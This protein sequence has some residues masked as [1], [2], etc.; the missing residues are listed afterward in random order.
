MIRKVIKPFNELST[1]ELY[2][3]L[4]LR[5]EVFVVEQNCPYLDCD[6]KDYSAHHLL[7]FEEDLLVA[8]CRV[9]PEGISYTGYSSIGRVVTKESHRGKNLG[10]DLMKEAIMWTKKRY[11]YPI[12]ISAQSYLE[13]FYCDLGFVV[14]TE[15][16]LED[17]IPHKGM[18]LKD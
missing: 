18:V 14:V 7:F 9:L 12:K 1:D 2:K 4:Q 3:I 17:D 10:R 5:M 15:E 8:Y 13:R 16:Y 11:H 6:N